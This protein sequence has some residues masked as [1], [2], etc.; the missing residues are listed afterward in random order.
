MASDVRPTPRPWHALPD[1]LGALVSAA[2]PG[3][4][5]E[6]VEV[7]GPAVPV[8]RTLDGPFGR[9]VVRAV[10]DALHEPAGRTR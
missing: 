10:A 9:D 5:D 1:D 3:I 2:I 6:L 7:L 8:S 4:A